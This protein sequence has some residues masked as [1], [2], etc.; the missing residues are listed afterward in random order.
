M[1]VREPAIV[2]H[3]EQHI[4]D[5]V[6]GFLDLVEEHNAI[7]TAADRFAELAAFF[8]AHIT[9]RRADKS[10]DGVLLHVLAHVN[11][12]HGV[13][14]VEQEFGQGASGFGFA[15]AGRAKKNE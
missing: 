2:Q 7:R 11:A 12:H 5:I 14:V 8:V 6:V 10:R 13:L 9:R 4:E 1:A 15:P 3:L